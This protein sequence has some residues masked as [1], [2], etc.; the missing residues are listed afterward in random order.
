MRFQKFPLDCKY[1]TIR[2]P[3]IHNLGASGRRAD[4]ASVLAGN[5]KGFG[6]ALKAASSKV[7]RKEIFVAEVQIQHLALDTM[8]TIPKHAQLENRICL[9]LE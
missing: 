3:K 5:Q 7:A 9:T 6:E 4:F 2:Q 1:T 8:T